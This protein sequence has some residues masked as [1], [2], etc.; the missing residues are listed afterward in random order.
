MG[1]FTVYNSTDAS[2]PVLTAEAGKLV[3]LLDACLVNGYGAKAAA[4]WAIAY[5]GTNK[6][7]YRAATGN[8]MYYRV[9]ND[10]LSA[11]LTYRGALVLGYEAMTSVDSGTRPFPGPLTTVPIWWLVPTTVN[12]TPIPWTIYADGKTMYFVVSNSFSGVAGSAS[13]YAFGEFTSYLATDN[14]NSFIG[15]HYTYGSLAASQA[16]ADPCWLYVNR[17]T[18]PVSNDYSGKGIPRGWTQLGVSPTSFLLTDNAPRYYTYVDLL[19]YPSGMSNQF[20]SAGNVIVCPLEFREVTE[21]SLM[22]PRGCLRGLYAWGH[23]PDLL[24]HGGTYTSTNGRVFTGI[25]AAQYSTTPYS[26][27]FYLPLVVETSATIT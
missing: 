23:L 18:S 17:T 6:R 3:D 11:T 10:S 16:I 5:T 7:A 25:K 13:L 22:I 24:T 4:G 21:L 9:Q 14:F 1:Q 26:S 15:G 8:R 2:A 19:N 27:V 20:P 12:T